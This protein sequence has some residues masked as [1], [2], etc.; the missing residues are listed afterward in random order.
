MARPK[1]IE[2]ETLLEILNSY[3]DTNKYLTKLKYAQL[4]EHGIEMGF[5]NLIYQDFSR[6]KKVRTIVETFNANNSISAYIQENRESA[7][8]TKI[9]FI[10]SDIVRKYGNDK[11]HLESVLRV[12]E[13]SYNKAFEKIQILESKI[14]SL[15]EKDRIQLETIKKL[16]A[17][18]ANTKEELSKV[19]RANRIDDELSKQERLLNALKMLFDMTTVPLESKEDLFELLKNL[20]Y[21]NTTDLFS[22]DVMNSEEEKEENKLVQTIVDKI[23]KNE[24]EK[25]SKIIVPNFMKR[26]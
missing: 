25:N 7:D 15:L 8:N 13:K 23:E 12:Y 17:K 20:G 3:V 14:E 22:L 21:K 18:T 9:N 11:K 19:K 1:K 10:P 2:T 5:E 4:V 26:K 24:K 16:R 6:N